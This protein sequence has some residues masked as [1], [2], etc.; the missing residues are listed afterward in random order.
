MSILLQALGILAL[1]VSLAQAATITLAWDAPACV[2]PPDKAY[3]LK[4]LIYQR[5]PRAT[6]FTELGAVPMTQRTKVVTLPAG[7]TGEACYQV[8]AV[9]WSETGKRMLAESSPSS[10]QGQPGCTSL[11]VPLGTRP[12]VVTRSDLCA[13]P[14]SR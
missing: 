6:T 1:L 3:S 8:T 9:Q 11:C 4:F 13:Q 10:I 2:P 14:R 5:G 12:T 7:K